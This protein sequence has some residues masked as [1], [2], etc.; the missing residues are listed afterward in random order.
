MTAGTR[1]DDGGKVAREIVGIAT[2][3]EHRKS[4]GK[5]HCDLGCPDGFAVAPKLTVN[6]ETE[7]SFPLTTLQVLDKFA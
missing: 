5:F 3:V 7:N 2:D 1:I 6:R 4:K